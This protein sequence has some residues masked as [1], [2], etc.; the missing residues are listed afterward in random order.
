METS[1]V[2]S[3]QLFRKFCTQPILL[4]AGLLF[5]HFAISTKT[6]TDDNFY[7]CP[8]LLVILKRMKLTMGT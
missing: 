1:E 5:F 8:G 3:S 7:H 6:G 2:I 4:Q